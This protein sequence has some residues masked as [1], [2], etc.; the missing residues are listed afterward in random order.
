VVQEHR[1]P[2]GT[3][4]V[5]A[6]G[7]ASAPAVASA[8]MP[9]RSGFAA[10]TSAELPTGTASSI[11]CAL[12]AEGKP[13]RAGPGATAEDI[14]VSSDAASDL[15]STELPLASANAAPQRRRSRSSIFRGGFTVLAAAA[16]A[17]PTMAGLAY[18]APADPNSAATSAGR[19]AG[20]A[21]SILY[22]LARDVAAYTPP[23]ASSG[24]LSTA[25]PVASPGVARVAPGA[26]TA[27]PHADRV[28]SRL[29]ELGASVAAATG[30]RPL[31]PAL[32][33]GPQSSTARPGQSVRL[34]LE[35]TARSEAVHSTLRSPRLVA[36]AAE[37]AEPL[38]AVRPLIA[39]PGQ[40]YSGRP[41]SRKSL[42]RTTA[43]SATQAAAVGAAGVAPVTS[44]QPASGGAGGVAN[45]AGLV[46][47]AAAAPDGVGAI[48][49]SQGPSGLPRPGITHLL[50]PESPL[51]HPGLTSG[52]SSVT[53]DPY[54][55]SLP[56]GAA[57]GGD[58]VR[59]P[60]ASGSG[61]DG[62][63]SEY[64]STL[65]GG[66]GTFGSST[67][68]RELQFVMSAGLP[69]GGGAGASSAGDMAGMPS[70]AAGAGGRYS[71]ARP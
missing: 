43:A 37:P 45:V 30:V 44:A 21:G 53:L 71:G 51:Q 65:Q 3:T 16:E 69:A 66:T 12:P 42:P 50:P 18:E 36:A 23:A 34:P 4:A 7:G 62:A 14:A 9:S 10:P 6:G 41:G 57:C 58:S 49:R 59:G 46:A 31:L 17:P 20:T 61:G 67:L 33:P 52:L 27:V 60:S 11:G 35:G 48:A 28:G 5:P 13:Q 25:S 26:G 63:G 19:A 15:G 38:T 39:L 56:L 32:S 55:S 68:Q 8:P 70:S 22:S 1:P 64:G 29:Q 54:A 47:A 24:A 2:V 40:A